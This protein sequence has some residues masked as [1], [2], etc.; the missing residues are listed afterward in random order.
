M[1]A[2]LARSVDAQNTDARAPVDLDTPFLSKVQPSVDGPKVGE[3]ELFSPSWPVGLA[4]WFG[5]GSPHVDRTLNAVL[6]ASESN[7]PREDLLV[8]SL[9]L[10]DK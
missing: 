7:P 8:G 10:H 2:T 6:C 4:P 1:S 3:I 5:Q 9:G